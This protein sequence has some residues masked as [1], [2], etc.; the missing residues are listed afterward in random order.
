[1]NSKDV[2]SKVTFGKK[3][4]LDEASKMIKEYHHLKSLLQKP[5]PIRT[6]KLD[7]KTEAKLENL[8][9]Q[10][11]NAFIFSKELIMRFFDGSEE[12]AAGNPKSSNYLM[13]ILGAHPDKQGVFDAGAPTVLA[14]GCERKVVDTKDGNDNT[15]TIERFIPLNI[16]KPASEYPGRVVEPGFI[17]EFKDGTV[18]DFFTVK[19]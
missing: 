10:D 19:K 12:D 14:L 8:T 6:V 15:V 4:T 17:K 5:I 7:L 9:N 13:L 18:V 16:D 1:M 3:F 2:Q 11:Y